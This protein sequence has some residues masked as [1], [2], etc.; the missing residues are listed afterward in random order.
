MRSVTGFHI[1]LLVAALLSVAVSIYLAL[2]PPRRRAC[3]TRIDL[4]APILVTTNRDFLTGASYS[5][6]ALYLKMISPVDRIPGARI[7]P[8]M[9]W[10]SAAGSNDVEWQMEYRWEPD[11]EWTSL[12]TGP[13]F[14]GDD[15]E[16]VTPFK[17][18][19]SWSPTAKLEIR[20]SRIFGLGT[21][22]VQSVDMNYSVEEATNG[23][24]EP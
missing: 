18:I 10:R 22:A 21:V 5:N 3:W 7:M 20:L 15:G 6:G 23:I 4:P 24:A 1:M 17:G 13:N 14:K 11:E 9:H 8:H 12:G 2:R 19:A 16:F